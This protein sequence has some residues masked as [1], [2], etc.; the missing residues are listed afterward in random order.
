MKGPF[1]KS[2]SNKRQPSYSLSKIETTHLVRDFRGTKLENWSIEDR[3]FLMFDIFSWS[4]AIINRHSSVLSVPSSQNV[5]TTTTWEKR[6]C[7]I[8]LLHLASN[9]TSTIPRSWM[10]VAN[11][12]TY[13][14]LKHSQ[15]YQNNWNPEVFK[16]TF[17]LLVCHDHSLNKNEDKR[18]ISICD[19]QN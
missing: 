10:K 5:E 14:D 12:I 9:T 7:G 17:R 15:T 18:F 2:L 8:L 6:Q 19:K 16:N 1:K 4:Y 13:L 3:G 11:T